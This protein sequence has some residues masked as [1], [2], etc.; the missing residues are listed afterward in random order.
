MVAMARTLYNPRG[1]EDVRVLSV[2]PS[3]LLDTRLFATKE[4]VEDYLYKSFIQA[5]YRLHPNPEHPSREHRWSAEQATRWLAFLAR[6]LEY[7]QNG[8]SDL[9]WWKLPSA[10]PK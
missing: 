1:R 6:N 3:E 5:S 2:N 4:A 8:T 9:M 10:V 7:R